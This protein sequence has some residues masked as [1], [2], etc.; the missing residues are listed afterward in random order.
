VVSG[1]GR[2]LPAELTGGDTALVDLVQTDAPISPGNSGG[3]LAD[4]SGEVVG[5]N[6]AYIPPGAGAES[7]GFAI[8][9]D[10][11]VMVADQL[12][13]DGEAVHPYLGVSLADAASEGSGSPAESGAV[14]TEVEPGG[15]SDEAGVAPEDVITAI[16]SVPVE[17][18]GDLLG[19]LR[20]YAPGEDVQLTLTRGG[21]EL[22]VEVPL[23]ER[24]G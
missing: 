6:V 18:S 9:S 8:P 20:D 2:E 19:A 4:R 17:D 7:L 13:E 3:A 14:V 21:E 12:I 5:V 11:V 22:T 15:P 23:G 16:G 10:T 1:V 24:D